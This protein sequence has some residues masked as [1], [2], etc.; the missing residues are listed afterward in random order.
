MKI[1]SV[2]QSKQGPNSKNTVYGVFL[3]KYSG[4]AHINISDNKHMKRRVWI[5]NRPLYNVSTTHFKYTIDMIAQSLQ[6]A[7]V[8]PG[9]R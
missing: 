2:Q 4:I 6:N 7:C 1:N 3:V 8:G 9:N 5:T